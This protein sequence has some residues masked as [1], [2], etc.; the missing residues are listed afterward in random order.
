M[1]E[2]RRLVDEALEALGGD[3]YLSITT[4]LEK[5]RMYSFYQR[6]LSGLSRATIYTKY[7]VAPGKPDINQLYIRERQAFGKNEKW[8]IL[9]NETDAYEV[10]FRGARPLSEEDIK[11]YRDRRRH[12]IF[13]IL[14]RR[15]NEE[16]MIFERRGREV[17]DNKP[18]EVVEIIDG[19]N[20]SVTV[21]FH[22]TTKLPVRQMY[23][24]R[25]NR[26]VRHEETSIFD[27]YKDAGHGVVLPRVVQR[28]R[29]GR[30]VFSM[31]AN[32]VQVNVPI[33]DN[34]LGLPGDIKILER[35]P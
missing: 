24:W 22:Y 30:K 26:R 33:D 9:F 11:R 19:N 35:E 2:G 4:K 20:D 12:D 10:T 17:I 31:F 32:S 34:T 25:D 5:G 18:V 15:L 14:L 21:Y 8:S 13:Y 27:K 28:L 23:A 6:Q 1:R 16:G 29:D 7:L 3:N